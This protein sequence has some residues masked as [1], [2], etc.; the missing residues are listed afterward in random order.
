MGKIL[1]IEDD[2]HINRIYSE[3]LT[4]EGFE[5]ESAR[6]A[7]DGLGLVRTK[8]VDLILLDIMLPGVMNG[9][10]FLEMLKKDDKLKQIPVIILTN[11]DT[12]K[13]QAGKYEAVKDYLVKANTD[14]NILVDKVRKLL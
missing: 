13:D 6:D 2:E 9:F 11:L 10:D 12:E 14:L 1:I 3:K 8:E 4:N 7:K 5:V